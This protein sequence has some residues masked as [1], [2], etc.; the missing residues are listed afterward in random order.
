V[1][2]REGGRGNERICVHLLKPHAA[3]QTV[4]LKSSLFVIGIQP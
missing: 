4:D 2:G 3:A 1:G